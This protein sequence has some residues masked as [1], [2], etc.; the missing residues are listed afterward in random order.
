M[1]LFRLSD[2]RCLAWQA[3]G[4][5]AGV[6]LFYFHGA[7][8]SRLEAAYADA[9]TRQLGL[10]LIAVDRPGYGHSTPTRQSGFQAFAQDVLELADALQLDRFGVVGMSAGG[11]HA[12]HLAALAGSR[13]VGVGLVNAS[14]NASD[15]A[16][17][18]TPLP[19][20]LL[21]RLASRVWLLRRFARRIKDDPRGLCRGAERT[22]AWA[23]AQVEQFVAATTEGMRQDGAVDTMLEE[24]RRVLCK[25]WGLD[26]SRIDGPV[27]ALCGQRDPGRWYYREKAQRIDTLSVVEIAGGHQPFISASAWQQLARCCSA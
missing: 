22:E 21:T 20:R 1:Q 10:R 3:Y 2:G 16:W 26:W 11:P 12:L 18:A 14:S 23:Q 5:P 4:E 13:V 9:H 15:D 17:R 6:P 24:A 25:D 8:S 19:L 7:G 27:L